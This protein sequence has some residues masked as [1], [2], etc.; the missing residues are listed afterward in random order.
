[1]AGLYFEAFE[2]G[3][4][5]IHELSRTGTEHDNIFFSPMTMNPRPL[6]ID[7]H[8]A[9]TTERQA[10]VQQPL[11]ARRSGA[12]SPALRSGISRHCDTSTTG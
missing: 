4:E 9:A 10:S 7:S 12:L 6:H 1:M 8:F 2:P 3:G 11:H 5:F